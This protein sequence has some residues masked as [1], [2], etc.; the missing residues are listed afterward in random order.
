MKLEKI[1]WKDID[2]LSDSWMSK[3]DLIVAGQESFNETC[4][5]VG[6]VLFENEDFLIIAGTFDGV[7]MWHDASMIMK[8][9]IVN[10]ETI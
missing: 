1:Y 9:V 4:I 2:G 6:E 7:E 5:S 10:R 8:S 3:E